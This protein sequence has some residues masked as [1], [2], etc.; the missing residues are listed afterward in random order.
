MLRC[1]ES[2][3]IE[4]GI[5]MSTPKYLNVSLP[6]AERVS[7]LISQMTVD[8]K[9]SFLHTQ[10]KAIPRLGIKDYNVSA[11]GAHGLLVRSYYDQWCYG[12]STVFP[13]PMGLSL[14][15]DMDLMHRV[16]AVIGDEAR[17]WYEKDNHTRWLTIWSPTIDMERDP[18]WGRTEEAYG[19]DP[20]HAGKLSAALIRGVQGDDPFYLK[21]SCAPKHFYGNNV[22]K[23]RLSASTDISERVKREY[24]LR[25]FE[26]AF[27]EGKA[28]SLMTAYNEINGIPCIVNPEVLD[29]VKG[30]WGC[31]GFIVC[32]GDDLGQT[33]TFHKY[34][35]TNAEA[36]ALAMKAGVDCF[37]DQK[38]ELVIDAA[39]EA[40]NKKLISEADIDLALTNILNLRFRFGQFDPPELNPFTKIPQDRLCCREHSETALEA[41]RKSIVLL[42]NDGILPLDKSTN[43]KTLLIGDLA[44]NNLADWYSGKPP[45]AIAPFDAINSIVKNEIVEVV[46]VHDI[47]VIYNNKTKS[48]IRVDEEGNVTFDGD[49]TTRTEFEEID[50]GFNSVSYREPKSGKYLALPPSFELNCKADTVWGW[51]TQELF[52][53]D[54][55]T[56]YFI[57]HGHLFGNRYDD[58]KNEQIANL[59]SDLKCE[60]ISDGIIPAVEEA[61]TAETVILM[62][63]NNPLING[64]E[65]F[66]RPGITFPKRWTELINRIHAVNPNIVLSLIAGYPFAFA[67]ELKKLRAVTYTSHG[68]QYVGKAV[69]EVLYGL[70][71][72][73]GRL[74]MTWYLSEND[75]PDINDYDIINN[76]RTYMYFDKPVQFPFGFGLSYT[77]FDYSDISAEKSDNGYLIS[78]N[79][80]NTGE[81]NGDEVVQLYATL[82]GVPVKAPIHKLCGFN[83]T[84]IN[85]G[86]SKKITFEVPE[87]EIRL[88]DEVANSFLIIPKSITF[89]IGTSSADIK[90]TKEVE[91]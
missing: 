44:E 40:Y 69:A 11:E 37:T 78:C 79:V 66:D 56:G 76:P 22:E 54:S 48:W 2:K 59:M 86:E 17:V 49:E 15:W 75:L 74:S 63:G 71:N 67:E 7:D 89:S 5:I 34:C 18:R 90:L 64:R 82:H 60:I 28:M 16:G 87:D 6:L 19:E 1:I 13:Q 27:R 36:I 30:E 85:S 41:Y 38:N 12:N 14:T 68:E 72:P 39:T 88:F 73:A 20:Y 43:G 10:Q 33:V 32:D 4:K 42:K 35:K 50:W 26:Y 84:H 21:A 70:Y 80:K 47:C 29:I 83:R 58:A 65:C 51:F 81:L 3:I 24:Y 52:L 9:I 23:N 46:R 77:K 57:P 25:V 53:R 62:L 55:A 61:K 45:E 31:E 8:E 91:L